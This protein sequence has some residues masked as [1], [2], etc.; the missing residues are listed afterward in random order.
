MI[1]LLAQAIAR[2]EG[3]GKPGAIPT[4]DNNP[5]DLEHAPGEMHTT[6]SPIGSFDTVADGWN[7]LE[8]QLSLYAGRGLTVGD[9]ITQFYAPPSEND[10]ARYVQNVCNFAHCSPDDLVSTVLAQGE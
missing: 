1:S 7:A 9:M 8:R 6:S 10:S 2:E 5:G 3:Y 4:L